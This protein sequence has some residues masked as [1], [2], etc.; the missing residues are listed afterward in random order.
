MQD[1]LRIFEVGNPP[2]RCRSSTLLH[3]GHRGRCMLN[4]RK[5]DVI[6]EEVSWPYPFRAAERPAAMFWLMLVNSCLLDRGEPLARLESS[7]KVYVPSI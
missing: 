6:G 1:I 2:W 3:L 4:R 5:E 7:H